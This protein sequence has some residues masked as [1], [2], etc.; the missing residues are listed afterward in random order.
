MYSTRAPERFDTVVIGGGQAGLAV[1][2]HLANRGQQLVILDANDRIGDPW[3]KRWDSLRLFTPARLDGLPGWPVPAA[4]WSF[5]TKDEMADYLEAYAARFGLPVRTGVVAERLGRNAGRF[6]VVAGARRY[7]ANNV[8]VATGGFQSPRLPAFATE[9]DPDIVQLH[10]SQ[11]R[12]P[13]QLRPGDV[14]VVG[15]AN[16]GADI[17]LEL[18][19]TCRT[20]LSGRHPG[21]EPVRPG[22]VWDRLVT[23]PFWFA[24]SRLLTV[25]TWAGQKLRSTLL[26]GGHPLARVKPKDLEAAGV[27]RL[28]KTVGIENGLPVVEDGRTVD[29]ANVIWCTGF[30]PDFRWIDLA[31]FDDNGL[32][33]HDRGVVSAEPGLYFVGLPFLFALTSSLVGGVGRDAEHIAEHIACRTAAPTSMIKTVA[34]R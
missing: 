5:P 34:N 24:A 18:S 15:A 29:V 13:A 7:E 31:V 17:A 23:P 26:S 27:Q 12:R 20:L 16:S 22:S 6:E 10:S 30:Q 25:R 2:Y 11:Y 32:P 9:L 14:L 3:R 21:T 28:P 19:R 4:A 1:G 33:I 8:V